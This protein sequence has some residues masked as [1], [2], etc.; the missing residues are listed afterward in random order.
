MAEEI[1]DTGEEELERIRQLEASPEYQEK[2]R[3]LREKMKVNIQWKM[4][5]IALV[6]GAVLLFALF[7]FVGIAILAILGVIF[8]YPVYKRKRELFREK[9]ENNEV[10]YVERFLSP[11]VKEIFPTGEMKVTPDFLL[12]PV[13]KVCPSSTNYR[14][15]TELCF[16][17]E[18]ELSVMNLYAYHIVESTDS[19]GR[20]SR[21]E[22]TDFYGQVFRMRFSHPFVGHIRIVPTEKTAILKR[23]VQDY[24]NKQKNELKIDTEDIT[25]NEHYNIFCTDEFSARRFL[26]PT[27]LDWFDKNIA[28]SRTAIYIEDDTM[29]ISRYT[30]YHLF[31]VP[32]TV[33]E[34]DKLSMVEEYKK[35]R[36][37]IDFL[38]SFTEVFKES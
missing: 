22:V 37:E 10:L 17:D 38:E 29:Y 2:L 23:E 26:N 9:K 12:D 1:R 15:N 21:K 19:K 6:I 5:K 30:G 4:Y 28:E 13:K 25:H 32:K 36:A 11:I 31:P 8:V 35:L 16:H 20:T 7:K 27:V 18:R 14:G 34:V 24:P 33:A 3:I